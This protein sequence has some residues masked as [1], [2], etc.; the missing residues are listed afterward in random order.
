MFNNLN[1]LQKQT[2]LRIIFKAHR[3]IYKICI[4]KSYTVVVSE[5]IVNQHSFA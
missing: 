3:V 2:P 4:L 1:S 5:E